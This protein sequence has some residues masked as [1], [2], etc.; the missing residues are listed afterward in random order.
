MNNICIKKVWNDENLIEIFIEA[1][2]ELVKVKQRCYIQEKELYENGEKI[3]NYIS[4]LKK[5]EIYIEFGK[6]EG[7]Y[8]PAFSMC[9]IKKDILG[10]FLIE[11]D[12]EIADIKN[13]SHWCKF[14][15]ETELG[16]IEQLAIHL[17]KIAKNEVNEFEL[18]EL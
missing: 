13:R 3:L 18:Y 16:R 9:F 10:H 17:I 5:D 8:T 11:M 15:I 12:M 6:K 14:Y 4:T 1:T 2:S 7:N